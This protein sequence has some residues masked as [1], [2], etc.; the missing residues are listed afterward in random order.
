MGIQNVIGWKA[1]GHGLPIVFVDPKNMYRPHAVHK[2]EN[3]FNGLRMEVC[4]AVG[5]IGIDAQLNILTYS[6]RPG[7]MVRA[8]L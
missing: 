7:E 6:S 5:E 3:G 4:A 1:R 8:I 2:A